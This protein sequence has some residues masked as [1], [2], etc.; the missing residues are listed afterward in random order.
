MAAYEDFLNKSKARFV[1]TVTQG[2][3]YPYF[4]KRIN[5][6]LNAGKLGMRT[7]R[8]DKENTKIMICGNLDFNVTIANYFLTRDWEEGNSKTAGSFVQEKAFVE[9]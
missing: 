7:G 4:N 8:E 5:D 2:D 3:S 9:R 6:L 1:P